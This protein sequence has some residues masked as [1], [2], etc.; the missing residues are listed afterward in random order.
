MKTRCE[1]TLRG[2][3]WWGPFLGYWVLLVLLTAPAAA[4]SQ[5]SDPGS[6][7]PLAWSLVSTVLSV[8]LQ[9]IF[10]IVL[11]RIVMPKLSFGGKTFSFRGDIGR[12]VGINFGGILLTIVTLS[13]YAPW[14]ARRVTAYLASETSF[15]GA[16]PRFLG[17]GGR[18]F[19]YFLLAL[20]LPVIVVCG[21]VFIAVWFS[22]WGSD[23]LV[24]GPVDA[25]TS[26]MTTAV[27][28]LI[29]LVLVPFMYLM[30]KWYVDFAWND[31][32]IAWKAGFWPS[33]GFILGQLL[34]T[35]ITAGIYWPAATV[36][37]YRYFAGKTAFSRGEAE[38]GRLGFDGSI[39]KGFGLFW[40]Q[41]LLC[42]IT[43]GIY[44]PWGLAAMG[45][46]L[47]SG[48]YYEEASQ[49]AAT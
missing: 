11:L 4:I 31:V 5:R 24:S 49:S 29:F 25:A 1:F 33:C 16:T 9:A 44:L 23:W 21:L 18:L 15:D 17:K 2:K 47:A 8:V 43:V 35:V 13:I 42:I 30:Y 41:T 10:T 37:L 39:G 19:T 27:T 45:R 12:Y 34:L 3:D 32:T 38:I 36:R 7:A 48:T 26:L 6:S 40:G 28:A 20:Y 46:W 22:P 14:Y